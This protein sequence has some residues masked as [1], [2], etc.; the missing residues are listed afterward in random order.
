MLCQVLKGKSFELILAVATVE[1]KLQTFVSKLIKFN[2]GS[3]QVG[4]VQG[5]AAQTRAMLFDITF[6]MLCLIVQ[7]YGSDVSMQINYC[8]FSDKTVCSA[9]KDTLSLAQT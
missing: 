6:L 2:E 1:G 9:M 3:K 4:G 7:M 8:N 5:K